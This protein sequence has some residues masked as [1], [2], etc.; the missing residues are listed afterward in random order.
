MWHELRALVEV[1]MTPR[2]ALSAATKTGAQIL[3]LYDQIGT[4]EPGK[5]ADMILL[6]GN[7][8]MDIDATRQVVATIKGGTIW[9]DKR[10]TIEGLEA[11]G[12]AYRDEGETR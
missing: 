8:L 10:R 7:P 4:I 11:L 1:G 6:D 2:Q 9:Y 5:Q 12:R 3:G